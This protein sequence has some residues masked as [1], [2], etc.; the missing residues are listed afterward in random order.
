LLAGEYAVLD[1]ARAIVAA[2][3]RSVQVRLRSAEAEASLSIAT[4]PPDGVA[5]TCRIDRRSGRI[6]GAAAPIVSACLRVLRKELGPTWHVR[7]PGGSIEVGSGDL[8]AVAAGDGTRVKLGLGS[9][10]A[11]VVGLLG[12]LLGGRIQP[13]QLLQW[14]HQAHL[15]LQ[16]GVGSGAD[17]AA[18]VYG[19]L[20]QHWLA[21]DES[22]RP[23]RVRPLRPAT[24]TGCTGVVFWTGKAA[25]TLELVQAVHRWAA[26]A[27]TEYEKRM[28]DLEAAAA[29]LAAAIQ[30]PD[31]GG[32]IGSVAA[33]LDAMVHLAEACRAGLV[34]EAHLRLHSLAERR[35]GAAKPTGAGGG[36]LA[37]AVLPASADLT[38]FLA[39]AER[40]GLVWVPLGLAP[41]GFSEAAAVEEQA[42][43]TTLSL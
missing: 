29:G 23:I 13:E 8:A 10:A 2:V 18:A 3:N 16:K 28:R 11:S 41:Q 40:E 25:S 26:S 1:G 12:A 17:V 36:D 34:L 19:G 21:P 42:P 35:G 6:H 7:L 15:G 39:D 27:P 5:A 4:V 20:L 32:L 14:S 9:S 30:K 37:L 38:A 24:R 43:E 33:G 31:A 22:D